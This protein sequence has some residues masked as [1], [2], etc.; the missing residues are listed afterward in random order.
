MGADSGQQII[1]LV[2]AH[3]QPMRSYVALK[4]NYND[5]MCKM[6]IGLR[7]KTPE[8]LMLFTKH[9]NFPKL[10]HYKFIELQ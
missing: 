10:T 2:N 5:L 9:N 1:F 7:N 4:T 3:N 6:P 8:E